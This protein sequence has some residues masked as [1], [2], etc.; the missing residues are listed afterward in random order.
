[1]TQTCGEKQVVG[2]GGDGEGGLL[3]LKILV[4]VLMEKMSCVEEE[5][6]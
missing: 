1:M 3:L 5:I 6:S 4:L 2:G